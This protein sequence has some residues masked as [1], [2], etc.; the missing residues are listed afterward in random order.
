MYSFW[1]EIC[2][3]RLDQLVRDNH[4]FSRLGIVMMSQQSY[5]GYG[6]L[7]PQ[8]TAGAEA[9]MTV[10]DTPIPIPPMFP[11]SDSSATPTLN[12]RRNVLLL[13]LQAYLFGFGTVKCRRGQRNGNTVA[14][15]N[16]EWT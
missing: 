15:S 3:F 4:P 6:Y 13:V 12:L 16:E 9:F 11:M 1:F 8:S 2:L 5:R 14:V 7:D 10:A